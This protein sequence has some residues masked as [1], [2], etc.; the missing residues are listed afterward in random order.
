MVFQF[1]DSVRASFWLKE[2]TSEVILD[3]SKVKDAQ[4]R[5]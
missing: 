3:T 5:G 4:T 1:Y 2:I